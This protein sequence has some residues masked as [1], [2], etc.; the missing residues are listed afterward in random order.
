MVA[1]T[2]SFAEIHDGSG[3]VVARLILLPW[4]NA[5]RSWVAPGLGPNCG[6]VSSS[7]S[8]TGCSSLLI[9]EPIKAS[10]Y[11]AMLLT[12][13]DD[14]CTVHVRTTNLE[15]DFLMFPAS[16]GATSMDGLFAKYH[17]R[18]C[19]EIA[20]D[21]CLRLCW[22]FDRLVLMVVDRSTLLKRCLVVVFRPPH[23][24]WLLFL[25]QHE[26]YH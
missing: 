25:A 5:D 20:Y 9:S 13:Q 24:S 23:S 11:R 15:T 14:A 6:A 12:S 18:L 8:R 1:G 16:Q 19:G 10:S 4:N 26:R 7:M 21:G 17:V 3:N 22:V 2:S